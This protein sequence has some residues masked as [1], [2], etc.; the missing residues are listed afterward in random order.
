MNSG[1]KTGLRTLVAEGAGANIANVK[2]KAFAIAAEEGQVDI[3][4]FLIE[5]GVNVND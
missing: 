5:E 4:K 3:L 1:N 2:A